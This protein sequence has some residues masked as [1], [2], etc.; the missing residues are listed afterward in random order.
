MNH[1]ELSELSYPDSVRY[2]Y[3]LGNELR[4]GAK[5]GLD[6][7]LVLLAALGNPERQQRFVHVAGTNGKGSTCA[8]I[9]NAIAPCGFSNGPIHFAASDRTY[10]THSD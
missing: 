2:L 5:F 8:M 7:M 4:V 10:R 9:A 3:S 1:C 6:R